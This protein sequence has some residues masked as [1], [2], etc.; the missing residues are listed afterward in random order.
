[1]STLFINAAWRDES[2]TEKLAR[3]YLLIYKL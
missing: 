1:M 2:R 3:E